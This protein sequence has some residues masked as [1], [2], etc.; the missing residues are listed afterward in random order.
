MANK[1]NSD[2]KDKLFQGETG[3]VSANQNVSS[4]KVGLPGIVSIIV[5][6][7]VL[8]VWGDYVEFYRSLQSG[9]VLLN[10]SEQGC[11]IYASVLW[12]PHYSNTP[13]KTSI[14]FFTSI[15]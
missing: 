12:F 6:W 9:D 8:C 5:V 14:F 13:F 15:V 1:A 4:D 7:G 3:H 10:M 11:G 2:S